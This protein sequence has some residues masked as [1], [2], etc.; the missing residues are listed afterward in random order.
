MYQSNNITTI[1]IYKFPLSQMLAQAGIIFYSKN[2]LM[3]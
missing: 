2:Y 3:N 1:E